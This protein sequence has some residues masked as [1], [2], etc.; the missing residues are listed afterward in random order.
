MYFVNSIEKD[1]Y[2][3][4]KVSD[5]NENYRS[6]DGVLFTKDGQTLVACPGGM[7]G[8]YAV[9]QGVT[10]IAEEAFYG[11]S[12]LESITIP[13]GVT[14]LGLGAFDGCYSLKSI[15]L[16][17]GITEIGDGAFASCSSLE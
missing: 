12:S 6:I 4:I 9:P 13:E 1:F 8:E 17:E 5:C 2:E 7:K 3:E 10:E 15:T 16:P 11:C 14:K